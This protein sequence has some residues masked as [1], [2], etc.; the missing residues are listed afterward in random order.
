MEELVITIIISRPDGSVVHQEFGC[1]NEWGTVDDWKIEWPV[2][3]GIIFGDHKLT[4]LI[5]EPTVR[6]KDGGG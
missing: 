5:V 6:L 4:K 3:G 2:G 1:L